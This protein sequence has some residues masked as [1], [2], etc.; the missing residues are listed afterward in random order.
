MI[1]L[2]SLLLAGHLLAMNLAAA[3]P[4]AC[5]FLQWKVTNQRNEINRLG[6]CL[7]RWSLLG[8]LGGAILGVL[9]GGLMWVDNQARFFTALER[10]PSKIYFGVWE[11]AF[12]VVCMIVYILWWHWRTPRSNAARCGHA[13]FATAAATN[14]LW[15][16]PALMV[17]LARLAVESPYGEP[18]DAAAFRELMF[19]DQIMS[20]W[21]HVWL[22]SFA[23]AGIVMSWLA[24]QRLQRVSTETE[25]ESPD[26]AA[27]EKLASVVAW[28]GRVA[29]STT[30][31]QLPV[32]MWLLIS[33]PTLEQSRLMGGNFWATG[34]FVASIVAALGLM[35]QLA[36]V[37]LR[38]AQRQPLHYAAALL[39][40]TV[41][42]MS[43]TLHLARGNSMKRPAQA[44]EPEVIRL[45]QP[46]CNNF[47]SDAHPTVRQQPRL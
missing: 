28:G 3:G 34:F 4:L 16:F 8:F 38:T 26:H 43:F 22:A 41:T 29:L 13:L 18:I 25:K 40:L 45:P 39:V 20:R 37:A 9:S 35:H 1:V 33:S 10:L 2:Q 44:R 5:I 36:A 14:L 23:T 17:V 27:S 21:L 24:A 32:G 31:L 6:Q 30:L 42:L 19:Q 47:R 12:Y 11:L 15:H 7:A 46:Y